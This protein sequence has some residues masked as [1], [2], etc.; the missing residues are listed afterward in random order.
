M[1]DF[2][3]TE[4]MRAYMLPSI[5]QAQRIKRLEK[6]N[7]IMKSKLEYLEQ[8]VKNPSNIKTGPNGIFYSY[9]NSTLQD[10]FL[11]EMAYIVI[12]H[13]EDEDVLDA[14][15]IDAYDVYELLTNAGYYLR[16]HPEQE[17][18]MHI[19]KYN[20]FSKA[21]ESY[22]ANQFHFYFSDSLEEQM[23]EELQEYADEHLNYVLTQNPDLVHDMS[24]IFI[25]IQRNDPQFSEIVQRY[26]R[27]HPQDQ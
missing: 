14:H 26:D 7:F 17:Q 23:G 3:S 18:Q 25:E 9:T 24:S 11:K 19:D 21:V 8:A 27:N 1:S 6:E 20:T 5:E 10:Y 13:L 12:S 22:L 2:N 16:N 4:E 15:D